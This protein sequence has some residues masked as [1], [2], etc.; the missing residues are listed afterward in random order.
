MYT[1]VNVFS[2]LLLLLTYNVE[3]RSPPDAFVRR[4][5]VNGNRRVRRKRDVRFL[6]FGEKKTGR[7]VTLKRVPSRGLGQFSRIVYEIIKKQFTNRTNPTVDFGLIPNSFSLTFTTFTDNVLVR[8]VYGFSFR[9]AEQ[10]KRGGG[11]S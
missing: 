9:G 11:K 4:N 7:D 2:L 3:R 10:C 6:D 5:N 8:W 1:R